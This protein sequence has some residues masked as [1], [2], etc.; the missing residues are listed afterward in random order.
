M[1]RSLVAILEDPDRPRSQY[2]QNEL[3][4]RYRKALATD[5]V[6]EGDL[7]KIQAIR[8]EF[9]RALPEIRA[10]CQRSYQENLQDQDAVA[11]LLSGVAAADGLFDLAHLLNGGSEGGFKCSSCGWRY[12]YLL[13]D[14]GIAIYA[15]EHATGVPYS[16]TAGEDRG[17]Q[18]F[19]DGAP[20]RSD[21]FILPIKE[22]DKVLGNRTKALLDL[23]DRAPNPEPALLLRNFLG[24]FVCSKCGVEGP[25]KC[26]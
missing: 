25:I 15:D 16:G 24:S 6:N 7:E 2:E 26:L 17:L 10:L 11:Y 1:Y 18:D 9:L 19:K 23:A 4:P 14:D 8:L 21:G 13:F 22:G 12:Q 20:S 3:L 5:P